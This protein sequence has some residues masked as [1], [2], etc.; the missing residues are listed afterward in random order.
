MPAPVCW[1]AATGAGRTGGNYTVP[2]TSSP[3]RTLN[4]NS[5]HRC[6]GRISAPQ[7]TKH[8]DTAPDWSL[9]NK[10]CTA[11]PPT[12]I[13]ALLPDTALHRDWCHCNA[14]ICA[15]PFPNAAAGRRGMLSL[16]L[17]LSLVTTGA[18]A[19]VV[20]AHSVPCRRATC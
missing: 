15:V 20:V 18:V 19:R 2:L 7:S 6:A 4:L 1:V 13:I 16:S 17:S 12:A 10:H 14:A 3:T 9:A 11:P 5:G 8:G